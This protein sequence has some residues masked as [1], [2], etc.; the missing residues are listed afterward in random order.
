MDEGNK[1]KEDLAAASL[2]DRPVQ[3]NGRPSVFDSTLQEFMCVAMMAFC[4]VM[5]SANQGA[6]ALSLPSLARYF[7]INGSALSWTTNSYSLVTCSFILLMARLADVFGRKTVIL[8]AFVWYALWNLIAGFMH[9]DIVFDVTRGLQGLAGAA[10][11]PAAAGVLGAMYGDGQRKNAVLA[12]FAAGAPVG[13]VVGLLLGGI[14][15]EFLSW[16]AIMYFLAILYGIFVVVGYFVIPSDEV[17]RRHAV[18]Q[19][20]AIRKAKVERG[21]PIPQDDAV[22]INML[23]AGDGS[24]WDKLKRIDY[25]GSFLSTAGLMLFVFALSEAEAAPEGWSTPY[26]IAIIVVGVI[27]I[28]LFITWEFYYSN[29]LMPMFIWKYPGFAHVIVV[30]MLGWMDFQGVLTYYSSLFFQD[31]K[32]Y[33]PILTTACVSPQ[34]IMGILVNVFA[35]YTLHIIPGRILMIVAMASFTGAALLWALQPLHIIYWAM[36]FPALIL[37][38]IGAD[39]AYNVGNSYSLAT[40]PPQLKSTAAGI[41]TVMMQLSGSIGLAATTS[42][43]SSLIGENIDGQVPSVLLHGY[44]GAYWFATGAGAL[45]LVLSLFLKIGTQGGKQKTRLQLDAEKIIPNNSD[46]IEEIVL[47]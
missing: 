47:S 41:F 37:S 15:S 45:G 26:I 28:G 14:C 35:G 2:A 10:A 20:E 25:L 43:V 38:V 21:E 24:K 12:T 1:E 8:C 22:M 40:V 32:G 31:I 18:E 29:P 44:R 33:S 36:S 13:F 34:A 9:D 19:A 42:I 46:D 27:L 3:S 11:T 5:N 30:V 4:P 6:I 17:M 39:L 7:Q 16:R 23:K